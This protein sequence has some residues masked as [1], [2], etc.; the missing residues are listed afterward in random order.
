M[1]KFLKKQQ[2]EAKPSNKNQIYLNLLLKFQSN[3]R[4]IQ[5]DLN[6]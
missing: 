4:I 6:Y 2:N 1:I 5:I 3:Q